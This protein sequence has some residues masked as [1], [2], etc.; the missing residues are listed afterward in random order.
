[1]DLFSSQALMDLLLFAPIF[2]ISLT[3]HEYAHAFVADRLGDSTARYLGRMTMDPMAHISW[4]GTVIFPAI[5]VLTHA[6]LFGWAN[7]VPVD[8]RNFKRPRQGM[9]LVAAAGPAS[10]ILLAALSTI[11]LAMVF[12]QSPMDVVPAGETLGL[13][14]AAKK[15]LVMS[16]SLNL[17][18]AFFNLI[19]IPPLDGSRILQGLSSRQ[20]A[21]WMDE[22]QGR[23]QILLLILF[24]VGALRILAVPVYMLMALM[25][26]WAGIPFA[27]L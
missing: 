21:D 20:F 24:F 10:N 17:F 2:I 16:V 7:P 15:M 22:N 11:I 25:F 18:L 26:E 4:L 13:T 19:P 9:A 3:F 23:G 5:S 12:K 6:P 1:M 14:E 27:Q 8:Q